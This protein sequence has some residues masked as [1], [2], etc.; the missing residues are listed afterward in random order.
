MIAAAS[1][2]CSQN[3]GAKQPERIRKGLRQAVT[4]GGWVYNLGIVTLGNM[5]GGIIFVALPYYIVAIK[6]EEK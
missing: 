5:V 1:V 4:I 3:L 2:F 6:K